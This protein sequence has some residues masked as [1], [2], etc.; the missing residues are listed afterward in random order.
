MNDLLGEG[1]TDPMGDRAFV[2]RGRELSG[3]H[4][5]LERARRGQPRL[6]AVEG[7]PGIGKTALVR[8]FLASAA[9]ARVLHAIGA[10]DESLLPYGVVA[11]LAGQL[12]HESGDSG[13]MLAM[14]VDDRFRPADPLAMGSALLDVIGEEGADPIVIV[15]DDAQWADVPSL[16]AL[17]F[18]VRRLRA[19]HVM[20]VVVARDLTDPRLPEGL[21]RLLA[22]DGTVRLSLGGLDVSQVRALSGH[23]GQKP[24]GL[25]AAERLRAHAEGNPL[26]LR[27]L[28]ERLPPEAF[29]DMQTPLPAPRSF[30]LLV[31]DRL[32]ACRPTA[33]R[34][35]E[36]ASVLGRSCLLSEA[37]LLSEVDGSGDDDPLVALDQ[38]VAAGLLTERRAAGAVEVRFAHPLTQAAIYQSL[39]PAG[40]MGMHRRA[41]ELSGGEPARLRHRLLGSDRPDRALAADLAQAGRRSAGRGL[42]ADAAE[43][44]TLAAQVAA[45][46]EDRVRLTGEA[47][48]ALL[49]D[50]RIPEA[51]ELAK[52]LGPDTDPAVRGYVSGALASMAGRGEAA[53][54]L[55]TE[56]WRHCDPSDDPALAGRIAEHLAFNR[57][58]QG[59]GSDG[60]DWAQRALELAPHRPG[61]DRA[62]SNLLLALTAS[63]AIQQGLGMTGDLPDPT[64]AGA[65]ELDALLGRGLLLV[66]TDEFDEAARLVAGVAAASQNSTLPFRLTAKA[67]LS[68]AEYHLGHWDDAVM[69][70]EA[71]TAAAADTGQTWVTAMAHG[72]AALVPAARGEWDRA[73]A[74]VQAARATFGQTRDLGALMAIALGQAHLCT[75]K[76]D[77]RTLVSELSVVSGL[78]RRAKDP[79][80]L[81]WH[82]RFVDALIAEEEL[83]RAEAAL[84]PFEKLAAAHERRSALAA[85]AR[86]RGNLQ[87]ARKDHVSAEAAYRAGIEHVSQ[88]SAPFERARLELDYGAYLRR[89][90]KRGLAAQQLEQACAVFERLS[91]RPYVE[92]C[93]AEL[94]ACGRAPAQRR[95]RPE[96]GLTPQ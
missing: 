56:A 33:R 64:M 9:A 27:A 53:V 24:L 26:Y 67:I 15:I 19:D 84:A 65:R 96:S 14:A 60:V 35:A 41:A 51:T 73:S 6:V 70:A 42:W 45:D 81:P 36:A 3:L 72:F 18:A 75:A 25:R 23:F 95:R 40:R 21:R 63:G 16:C 39:G 61:A 74:H 57:L 94:E 85:A 79:A 76:G 8:R 34:L 83:D 58:A 4:A 22:D 87:A 50:G 5:E 80:V 46:G 37:V 86:V 66:F 48:E 10:E 2:G 11:Q 92:R 88:L 59:H 52:K 91:A 78:S 47:V 89:R 38:L 62:W 30:E 93:H 7:S 43:H 28:L 31:C 29:S 1:W 49:F 71:A 82:D 68:Y 12:S 44:L 69:H 13:D 90:G 55:L 32:A 54:A 17:A 77:T 20:T